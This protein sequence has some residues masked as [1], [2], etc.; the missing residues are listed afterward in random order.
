M[1]IM[2]ISDIHITSPYFVEEWA[3]RIVQFVSSTKADLLVITGDLTHDGYM[4]EYDIL[5]DYLAR[6]TVKDM[7]IVPG[8]HDARNEGYALFEEMFKTRF[9]VFENNEI[10][11]LGLDSSNPD[12]DI[13][14]VGRDNYPLIKNRLEGK[15]KLKALA[16]HHHLIPIPGTGRE[17]QI[18]TDAGDLLGLCR[19]LGIDFV[20]SGHRHKPWVWKLENMLFITAGTASTRRLKGRSYPS[21]N[22]IDLI[23]N[24]IIL[25]RF[26]V[27]KDKVVEEILLR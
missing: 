2:H 6:F 15:N 14:H 11:L 24:K 26:D 19:E 3:D 10:L 21:F 23:D 18:P 5:G 20:L 27:E 12:I 13:G 8:N 16:L 1:K 4:H 7:L 22:I 9:P 17:R 25:K